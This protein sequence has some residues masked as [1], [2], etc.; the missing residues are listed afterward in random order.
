MHIRTTVQV[1]QNVHCGVN[2]LWFSHLVRCTPGPAY[3][4]FGWNKEKISLNQNRQQELN[5]RL[6]Q[7]PIY[8]EQF[9]FQGF[10]SFYSQ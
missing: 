7:T 3:N 8:N 9:P 1:Q 2:S 6:Q 4:E 10:A 5:V